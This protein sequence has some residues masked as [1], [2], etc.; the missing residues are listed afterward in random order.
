MG[1]HSAAGRRE[2]HFYRHMMKAVLQLNDGHIVDQAQVDDVHGDFRVIHTFQR[3]P[4]PFFQC[5]VL[6]QRSRFRRRFF[7]S[8]AKGV[9]VLPRDTGQ[10]VVRSHGIGAAQY[11]GDI[12]AFPFRQG[13]HIPAGDL[14]R[15]H[16]SFEFYYLV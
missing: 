1:P 7:R 14:D 13:E 10:A 4:D 6:I 11:L 2:S 12:H 15:R 9:R 3:I 5:G 16:F 8:S